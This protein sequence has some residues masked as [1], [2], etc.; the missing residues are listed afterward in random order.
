MATKITDGNVGDVVQGSPEKRIDVAPDGSLWVCLIATGA[1]GAAKFFR[2]TDTGATWVYS[3]TSDIPLGQ[4]TAAP[5]FFVDADGYAHVSWIRWSTDPQVVIYAR[6]KPTGTGTTSPGWSWTYLTISPASGR[7]GVDS[8]VVA[9]RSGSGWVAFV[10]YGLGAGSGGSQVARVQISSAGVLSVGATTTGPSSGTSV[11][12]FGSL[13]F[14]HTG[15]GKTP[16]ALPHLFLV[17]GVQSTS[18]SIRANRAVYSGGTWTWDTPVVLGTGNMLQTALCTVWDGALLMVAYAASSPT[19]TVWE[20][21]GVAAPVARNPPAAPGG[22]GNVLALSLSQDP[23]TDD[24]YLAYYDATDGD[25]RW[26]KFTR[27]TTTWSAWAVAVTRTA[28]GDDGKVQ[29][30]RHPS[31]DSVD[32]LYANGSSSTWQ[33]YSQ[34]LVPLVR[35]PSAPTLISPASGANV[36]LASGATFTWTYNGVSPGDTQQAWAF[37]RVTGA[38][39]EYWSNAGQ[40][41]S[42]TI[43]WNTTVPATP[44]AA[45]FPA[46]KWTTSTTYTWTVRT[47]SATGADSAFATARTVVATTAP[48]VTV[49]TPSGIVYGDSTPLVNWTYTGLNAQRDYQVRI[50]TEATGINPDATTPVWDSGVVSSAIA[51]SVRIGTPLTNGATYRAYVRVTDAI[52]VQSIWTYAQFTISIAPPSGPLLE[53]I[54][55]ISYETGVP[56]VRLDVQGQSSFLTTAQND[57]SDGWENDANT[58][59]AQQLP[60]STNAL[61][62]GI[63]M[64]SVASGLM[65]VRTK[66]GSPPTAPYGV[67]QPLGPLSFPVVAGVVYTG[68]ASFRAAVTAR[69]GRIRIRWYD[70]DDGTGSLISESVGDQ[71]TAATGVYTQAYLTATAPTAAKLARL[72]LEVLGATAASEV[73]YVGTP[74][75]HPG[76]ATVWQ[77]GGYSATQTF[78]VER[79]DDGGLTW[80]ALIDRIKP[81]LAQQASDSDRLMPFGVDVLYRSYTDVDAGFGAVLESAVSPTATLTVDADR[82]AV[83]DPSDDVGEIYALV[84]GHRRADDEQSSVHRPAGR[85]TPVVDTEG[86]NAPTGTLSI[87]VLAADIDTV[88]GILY[89]T[90]A[91]VIQSPLGALFTC[92]I[93]RRDYN[94][95]SY[96]HRVI[97]CVYVQISEG[98]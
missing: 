31:R 48:A 77:P 87:Y 62:A 30:V 95:E 18:T 13:E 83:R 75:L 86:L 4:G 55:A 16:A 68:L 84:V 40:S 59:V 17:T 9:F 42:G 92:R 26:S 37:Q 14:N 72:V 66:V 3:A 1:S 70:A 24:I 57:G 53:T 64:T 97:D 96:R 25:I 79:S 41:W 82:W 73:F 11:Y 63:T 34:Q 76:R 91:F 51:R 69:A 15:D 61:L 10:E 67:A 98:P 8:D 89:R 44:Y 36:D 12:Q 88:V 32:M 71:V 46:G 47:R 52:A 85:S 43:V 7:T 90:V 94:V 5:S 93:I 50:F 29:L 45:V 38:T 19:I 74:S 2:S 60:D 35:A 23:V 65:G 58:T 80:N 39:T 81:T 49:T 56:R 22:T 27:A 6:G 28:S 54:T 20:W 78:R 33:V 21:D